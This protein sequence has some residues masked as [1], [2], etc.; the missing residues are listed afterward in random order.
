MLDAKAEL[1][2]AKEAGTFYA[3]EK[4]AAV[5]AIE[6]Y[7]EALKTVKTAKDADKLTKDLADKVGTWNERKAY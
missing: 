6:A 2:H 7:I 4:A 5:A 1:K 3:P